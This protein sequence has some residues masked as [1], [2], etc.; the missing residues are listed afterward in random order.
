MVIS[1]WWYLSA[2]NI[3][4]PCVLCMLSAFVSLVTKSHE[5]IFMLQWNVNNSFFFRQLETWTNWLWSGRRRRVNIFINSQDIKAPCRWVTRLSAWISIFQ[6]YKKESFKVCVLVSGSFIQE[7]NSW[8]VQCITRPFSQGVE[9]R[10]ERIRR[11]SV[12]DGCH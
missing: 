8:P 7:R 3:G 2:N 6:M 10:R 5:T 12:S 1:G 9:R 4:H 11:N